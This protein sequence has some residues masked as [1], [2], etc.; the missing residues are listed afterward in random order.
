MIRVKDHQTERLFDPWKHFGPKRRRLL[1]LSWSGAFRKFLF[2]EIP[3]HKIFKCFH[4]N[5]GRPTKEL[6]TAIGVTILQQIHDLP[7]E[8]AIESLAFNEQWHYALD[9]TGESD[10]EKYLCEKTLRTYRKLLIKENLD[11]VIFEKMTDEL[12]KSFHVD[13]SK[14]R[15]DSSHIFSN[16]RNLRRLEIFVKTIQKF[17][18]KLKI[19]YKALFDSLISVELQDRYL[20]EKS[21]GCFS[22][23]KPSASSQTLQQVGEDLL[24]L[25]ELFSSNK[26]V[27]KFHSYRLLQRV[28]SEQC[29]VTG[30]GEDKKLAIKPAKEVP[31]NSLQ[32]PSDPDATYDGHKGKGFQVQTM[33]TFQETEERDKTKPNLITYVEVEQA[34]EHDS[35]ALQPALDNTQD[36]D[37]CPEELQCDTLYG[38]DENV[39]QAKEKGV[40]VI[41]PVCGPSNSPATK[42]KD[43]QFDESTKLVSRCP[44][45]H[46]PIKVRRLKHRMTA[47]FSKNHCSECQ[48]REN[49][50]VTPLKKGD[51]SLR[52]NEKHYRLALR[53]ARED[54]SEFRNKYRWRAGVEATESHL[55]RDFGAGQLRVTG[56]PQVRFAVTLKA[57]GLNIFRSAKALKWA[58]KS[59]FILFFE[60][61]TL[62]ESHKP[63]INHVSLENDLLSYLVCQR[64][65]YLGSK[66]A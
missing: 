15:L 25:I 30:K 44:A 27:K 55:K 11:T 49:C 65:I 57:L 1:D 38:S 60:E 13:T 24:F 3:A 58:Y 14:Q 56:L 18:K 54:T 20:S 39:Q 29:T 33:E 37:C 9:I 32:N 4:K 66:T 22:K 19:V 16:M 45:G 47:R 46:K 42:L 26:D 2:K 7:D 6:Y 40:N 36:R 61:V 35:D 64:T 52:Y 5:F 63:K 41:A 28:L 51:Y 8:K 17:L 31:S 12:I 62:R 53:R 50:P 23:V 21:D 48:L 43:F 59:L 10:E 34:H